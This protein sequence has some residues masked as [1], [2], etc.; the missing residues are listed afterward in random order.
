[1]LVTALAA[2]AVACC[3]AWGLLAAAASAA[4]SGR[5]RAAQAALWVRGTAALVV[6][7]F[8]LN[9]MEMLF[10][11]ARA[12]DDGRWAHRF[13]WAVA[14]INGFNCFQ[15]AFLSGLVGPRSLR[16]LAVEAFERINCYS[17]EELQVRYDEFLVYLDDAQV[18]WVRCRFLRHIAGA[19]SPMV[20]C[21][22][23]PTTEVIVGREGLPASRDKPK[24]RFVVSHPWLTKAHPDPDGV[25]LR[26]LVEQLDL[27]DK[28]KKRHRPT[29]GPPCC[30]TANRGPLRIPRK[31]PNQSAWY[32]L[33]PVGP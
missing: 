25:Q 13:A 6:V 15:V 32:T 27:L 2:T 24:H 11:A 29:Y 19:G 7:S 8:L 21:Q 23:V 12:I 3:G 14:V 1:M 17:A 18:R 33:R 22:E 16:R 28:K 30:A 26:A 20:R 9:F 31:S 5:P 4:R 10:Q